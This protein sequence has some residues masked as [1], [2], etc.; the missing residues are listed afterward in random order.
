MSLSDDEVRFWDSGLAGDPLPGDI[1]CDPRWLSF[2]REL[3]AGDVPSDD[4][5]GDLC[6]LPF[7]TGL[8]DLDLLTGG[9]ISLTGDLCGDL[10]RLSLLR[11]HRDLDLLTGGEIFRA[12]KLLRCGLDLRERLLVLVSAFGKCLGL[13]IR[14]GFLQGDL[15]GLGD[16]CRL[17]G[18]LRGLGDLCRLL[19][20]LRG[21]GDLCR[22]GARAL[23]SQLDG[24]GFSL[25]SA[26]SA[27]GDLCRRGA[28]AFESQLDGKGFC[29]LSAWPA[30]P[31][32]AGVSRQGGLDASGLEPWRAPASSG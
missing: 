22:R 13:D 18:D 23:E 25:L 26:W 21:L 27:F 31:G 16:L 28:R 3:L 6:R 20:D 7:L 8:R 2:L 9:G 11:G 30:F 17:L 24:K 14:W 29:L 1:A 5:A 19:G 4:E 32:C 10:C 15:R 12:F